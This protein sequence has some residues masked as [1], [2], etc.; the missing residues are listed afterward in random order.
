MEK[1]GR[2][3]CDGALAWLLAAGVAVA[4]TETSTCVDEEYGSWDSY[5]VGG[6]G[7][8]VA[9]WK[10][11]GLNRWN[12]SLDGTTKRD[13]ATV[14]IPRFVVA[15]DYKFDSKWV[16]GVEVE[17][18]SGGT[19][20]AY[21]LEEQSGSENMEYETEVEKGGEVALE[22]FHLT[23]LILPELNVRVGHMVVPVGLTNAHHEPINFFGTTRPEGETT[24]LPCTWHETGLALFGTLGRGL[25]RFDYQ[26]MVVAGL[27]PNGFDKYNWVKGGKQGYFETDNF[28]S[29][30][31]VLR[32]D[33]KGVQGLRVGGSFYY[34]NDAGKNADKLITYKSVGRLPVKIFTL[35]AQYQN[36][37]VVARANFVTGTLA[38]PN[39][40]QAI[41]RRYS[42]LSPY[43]RQG[44]IAHRATTY[45]A[46]VGLNVRELVGSEK[47][48]V[49]MPFAH[50]EYFN[51]QEK[52][53]GLV[54]MDSRCQVSKWTVGLN[55]KPLPNL[56]VKADY[57]T[58]QIGVK[59]VFGKGQFNSENEYSV[60]IAY[61]GWFSKK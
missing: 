55:W 9:S 43:S 36:R 8:M 57:N 53:D 31:W 7:E 27:N 38:H 34:C 15:G 25:A 49:L 21:E 28:S 61:A 45:S 13:H 40:I 6:Y 22:Q 51:P 1:C 41:N 54:T 42:N 16:L 18:E 12:G 24:L 35:D 14:A 29:P 23:R 33:Y 11:Y 3:L 10:D 52:G 44:S 20:I 58:R 19:G 56:V 59:K 50:Y 4:Q 46:E 17:F 37:F 5:R 47:M 2:M 48:P 26:A 30:A 39:E 60:G 32:V